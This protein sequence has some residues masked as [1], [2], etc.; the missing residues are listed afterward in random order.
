MRGKEGEEFRT[1]E[2]EGRLAGEEGRE[3]GRLVNVVENK[4]CI[5]FAVFILKFKS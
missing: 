1:K 2:I 3:T 4:L 5:D